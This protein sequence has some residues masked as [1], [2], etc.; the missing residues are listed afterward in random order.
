MGKN[1]QSPVFTGVSA[2]PELRRIKLL[3]RL[4]QKVVYRIKIAVFITFGLICEFQLY[5]GIP[6]TKQ[7]AKGNGAVSTQ[8]QHFT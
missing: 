2:V 8:V 3:E 4:G 7:A 1:S 5:P 6:P